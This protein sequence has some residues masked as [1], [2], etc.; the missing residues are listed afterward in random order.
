MKRDMKNLSL[1]KVTEFILIITIIFMLLNDFITNS[2]LSGIY[3][4]LVV[5]SLIFVVIYGVDKKKNNTKDRIKNNNSK[6]IYYKKVN[7]KNK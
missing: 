3:I 4:V 5:I 7:H 2:I 6:M 1:K